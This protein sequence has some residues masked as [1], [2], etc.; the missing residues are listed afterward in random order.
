M[1]E[2]KL[3]AKVKEI[4][5]VG[6]IKSESFVRRYVQIG[7]AVIISVLFLVYLALVGYDVNLIQ[8][9]THMYVLHSR[10]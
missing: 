5:F 9:P 4:D 3:Y 8:V 1:E 2:E 10:S 6:D 7:A